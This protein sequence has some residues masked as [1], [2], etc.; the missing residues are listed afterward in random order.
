MCALDLGT[1]RLMHAG[2]YIDCGE[3]TGRPDKMRQFACEEARAT[4]EIEGRHAFANIGLNDTA[5]VL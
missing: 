2:L 3:A 5:R 4:P 1:N